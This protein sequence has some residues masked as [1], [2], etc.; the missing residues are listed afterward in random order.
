MKHVAIS[1]LAVEHVIPVI[2]VQ[3]GTDDEQEGLSFCKMHSFCG[4]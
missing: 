2:D 4:W 3:G 1:P